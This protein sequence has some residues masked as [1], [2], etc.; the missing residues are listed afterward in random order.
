MILASSRSV[1]IGSFTPP[2][3]F[4]SARPGSMRVIS[5]NEK[6]LLAFSGLYD[7]VDSSAEHKRSRTAFPVKC[8][9]QI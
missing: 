5:M 2:Y 7:A 4:V 3:F 9:R 8:Q 6:Q 1:R